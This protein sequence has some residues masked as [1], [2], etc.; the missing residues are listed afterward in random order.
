M[1]RVALLVAVIVSALSLGCSAPGPVVVPAPP[2]LALTRA[3]YVL[4]PDPPA[5]KPTWDDDDD[6]ARRALEAEW[7]PVDAL[8]M[9]PPPPPAGPREVRPTAPQLG[10]PR[11]PLPP[12][13]ARRPLASVRAVHGAPQVERVLL[14]A[15][16]PGAR[17]ASRVVLVL[18]PR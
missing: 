8:S 14:R 3:R 9:P 4:P 2:L 15:A 16:P 13:P 12:P 1:N 11:P 7:P 6:D 18:E 17:G 10:R 5:P